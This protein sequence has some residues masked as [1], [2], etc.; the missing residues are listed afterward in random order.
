MQKKISTCS[1]GFHSSNGTFAICL[2]RPKEEEKNKKLRHL[3]ASSWGAPES[4]AHIIK[5][6]KCQP[7][8]AA[9]ASTTTTTSLPTT[10]ATIK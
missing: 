2:A 5:L 9:T 3:S 7:K 8:K 10:T 1:R 6:R 4:F